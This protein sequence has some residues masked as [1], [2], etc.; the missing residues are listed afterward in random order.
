ML[1]TRCRHIGGRLGRI[2]DDEG[3]AHECIGVTLR[4]RFGYVELLR[5]QIAHV[6]LCGSCVNSCLTTWATA[7][8]FGSNTSHLAVVR[9]GRCTRMF[10]RC[11]YSRRNAAV[12]KLHDDLTRFDDTWSLWDGELGD[13]WLGVSPGM[14]CH[15]CQSLVCVTDSGTYQGHRLC[16]AVAN[17]ACHRMSMSND[18]LFRR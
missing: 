9:E 14:A 17:H 6:T 1:F 12:E 5:S 13:V 7:C 18:G 15:G 11:W 16:S 4:W 10:V 3:V 8:M 2:S